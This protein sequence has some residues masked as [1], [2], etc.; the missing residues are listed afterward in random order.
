[1]FYYWIRIGDASEYESFETLAEAIALLN[2]CGVGQ[3]DHWVDSGMG[4]GIDTPNFH[5]RDFVS[6]FYGDSAA[7]PV[8]HLT[9][10]EKAFVESQLTPVYN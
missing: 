1:M 4:I 8:R 2:E 10:W 6:L 3:V 9:R 5:G 7:Q